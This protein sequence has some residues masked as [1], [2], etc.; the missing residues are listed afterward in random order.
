VTHY[1]YLVRHGEHQD[2]EHGIDDGPL[3]PRGQR[4]AAL[5]A[6]RLSGVPFDAVWH[7]PLERAAQTARAVAERLPSIM[8]TPT[9]LLFDC[10]P[11]EMTPDTP[12]TF[13]PFF[14]AVTEAET[15]AG[16]AQMA[17]A[18]S[19]FLVRK[20][21][22]V[23][24][25]LITHNFVIAWFVR[26]VM[27]APE[28]RWLTLNQAN[29]GLTVLAQRKGRPWTLVTHNDLAHLP[30]ELRTGLPETLPV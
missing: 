21:G 8:P 29:C 10:V 25:L 27:Q 1:L 28:W 7:S 15:E 30:F 24:E 6:D 2:A 4:Q 23:H 11:T 26:E 12:S 17:D 22:E 16:R 19:E 18:T 14:G 3:S 9:A 20:P 5:L 13:E